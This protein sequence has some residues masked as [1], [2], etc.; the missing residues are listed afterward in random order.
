MAFELP[1]LRTL[2][3]RAQADIEA[4]LPGTNARLRRS[5]LNV[6]A[7]VM[8]GMAR[9]MYAFIREF[10]SQ[11]LPWSRGFLLRQWAEVW[12][13]MQLPATAAT[14]RVTLTGTNGSVIEADTLLQAADG[15]EYATQAEVTIAAGVAL[16]TVVAVVPGAAGNLP[17]ATELSLVNPI[18]G[19]ASTA[20]VDGT[21][22]T[23][24]TD[25]EDMDSLY[26][27]YLQR[28]QNPA[29]GGSVADYITWA[30]EVPG[31][32]RVWVYGGLDG[33]ATV[34][35]YFVRDNDDVSI[36]PDAAA[37]A[38]VQA[39]INS[40]EIKPVAASVGVYA[41]TSKVVNYTIKLTPDT[42]ATRAAVTA[43]LQDLYA[44]EATLGGTMLKSHMDEAISLAE[45]ETDHVLVAPTANVTALLNEIPVLGTIT[46]TGG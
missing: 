28:V 38:A 35:V 17:P 12:G 6:L 41:P 31:V 21:G 5:N 32:T 44:R 25:A 14:G 10:I 23:G 15:R 37:V 13:V 1:D 36:I 20:T 2:I 11:C 9:G 3:S 39:H 33:D 40:Q 42:A 24:G 7:R 26:A 22:V 46:F 45:G 34:Q 8:A 19:V 16:A 43:E 27:R 4:E 30:R 18:A 29:H